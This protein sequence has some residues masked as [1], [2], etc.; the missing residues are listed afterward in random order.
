MH[1]Y[2]RIQINIDWVRVSPEPFFPLDQYHNLIYDTLMKKKWITKKEIE[3][4]LRA[5]SVYKNEYEPTDREFHY[6]NRGFSR[7][8]GCYI[9]IEKDTSSKNYSRILVKHSDSKGFYTFID[10]W[11]EDKDGSLFWKYRNPVNVP[12]SDAAYIKDLE[13]EAQRMREE[14]RKITSLTHIKNPRGAGRKPDFENRKKKAAEVR[15]L[16]E[17]GKTNSEI[18]SITGMSR[19]S[20]FRYKKIIKKDE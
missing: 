10:V 9:S 6:R 13:E 8:L 14:Y 17:A 15:K 3:Q 20:V 12:L 1:T 18:M 2:V 11:E 4:I 16:M 5:Y 19:S 7:G